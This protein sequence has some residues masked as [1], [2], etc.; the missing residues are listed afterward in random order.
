MKKLF[1]CFCLFAVFS[2]KIVNDFEDDLINEDKQG[3]NYKCLDPSSQYYADT[4]I[5]GNIISE[6]PYVYEVR[7]CDNGE[8]CPL[9]G[10][11]P[12]KCSSTTILKEDGET[13]GN[14]SEC[15]S[16]FCE[17]SKCNRLGEGMPCSSTRNCQKEFY[18][19]EFCVKVRKEGETCTDTTQCEFG[20]VCGKKEETETNQF[21]IREGTIPTGQWADHSETCET[22]KAN[23]TNKL[24]ADYE[25]ELPEGKPKRCSGDF[26]CL[27]SVTTTETYSLY[28]RCVQNVNGWNYCE[29]PTTYSGYKEYLKEFQKVIDERKGTRYPTDY[30]D[31]GQKRMKKALVL[32]DV[33]YYG[34][35]DCIMDAKFGKDISS[36]GMFTK[37]RIMFFVSLICLLF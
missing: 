27:L 36:G 15:K 9:F 14:N 30:D 12:Y 11:L 34:A 22:R 8:P 13:C 17:N 25:Y 19:D 16:S 26:E 29:Y 2:S 21:C 32:G 31:D 23:Y 33:E 10:E 28:G 37:I 5:C 6:N 24:C 7:G 1:L 4:D 20:H 3:T 35:S 18:C